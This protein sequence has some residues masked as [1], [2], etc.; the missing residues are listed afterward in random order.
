MSIHATFVGR[1]VAAPKQFGNLVVIRA[2]AGESEKSNFKSRFVDLKFKA[3]GRDGQ[4][5]LKYQA[6]EDIVAVGEIKI[7]EWRNGKGSSDVMLFPRLETPWDIRSR[8][9]AGS[10]GASVPDPDPNNG[11]EADE[12][13][14]AGI[15]A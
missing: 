6:K 4:N 12:D 8:V 14:F 5:A 10:E 13:P 1:V 9:V 2:V 7:E 3:D 11:E 15:P